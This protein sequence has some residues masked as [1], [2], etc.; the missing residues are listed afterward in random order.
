MSGWQPQQQP[1]YPQQPYGQQPY[2]GQQAWQQP[3]QMMPYAPPPQ[4]PPPWQPR[5]APVAPKSTGLGLVLGLLIPGAGCMYAD[6]VGV[7]VVILVLW[8]ISIPL[9][10]VALIGVLTGLVLWI[11]SAVL[12]Y[13][14]TRDWNT[15]RG[16]VSL[17][18]RLQPRV[19]GAES[20]SPL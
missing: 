17:A 18:G 16:I 4:Y 19:L 10:F 20:R 15:A 13:T 12:G 14:M 8:L 1:Q 11:L 2:G 5:P 3:G 7:G 9:V 6:R